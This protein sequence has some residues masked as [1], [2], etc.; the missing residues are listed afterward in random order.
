MEDENEEDSLKKLFE[1]LNKFLQNSDFG[2]FLTR[3]EVISTFE[4]QLRLESRFETKQK[5]KM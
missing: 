3:L 1:T 2:Q 4:K 5:S